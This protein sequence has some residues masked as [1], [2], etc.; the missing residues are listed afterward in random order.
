MLYLLHSDF[1]SIG[2]LTSLHSLFPTACIYKTQ[3]TKDEKNIHLYKCLAQMYMISILTLQK[4]YQNHMLNS[5]SCMEITKKIIHCLK[6]FQ[7]IRKQTMPIFK[8]YYECI[9]AYREHY[10]CLIMPLDYTIGIGKF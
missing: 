6:L 3:T 5:L 8:L 4:L 10:H 7:R 2:S 1:E 9:L